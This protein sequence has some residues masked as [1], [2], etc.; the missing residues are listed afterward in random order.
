MTTGGIAQARQRETFAQV[1]EP[2][3]TLDTAGAFLGTWWKMS[4]DGLEWDVPDTAATAEVFGYPGTG[5]G[6]DAGGVSQSQGRDDCRMR[7]ACASAGRDRPVRF[8]GSG[9]QSLARELYPRLE[10]D[11]PLIADRNFYNWPA[12]HPARGPRHHKLVNPVLTR[13]KIG[14]AA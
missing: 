13:R 5:K 10:E 6:R 7:V 1:A 11:W 4:I 14:T 9:E 12:R 8:Q 3:A 2:V